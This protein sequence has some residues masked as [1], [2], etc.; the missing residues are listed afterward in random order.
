MHIFTTCHT[1]NTG[2]SV[3]IWHFHCINA[4]NAFVARCCMP[5]AAH[6][7]TFTYILDARIVASL[8]YAHARQSLSIGSFVVQ[9]TT[10]TTDEW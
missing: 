6:A 3:V 5:L 4:A 7:Y 10:T 8:S 1:I 2:I 9:A